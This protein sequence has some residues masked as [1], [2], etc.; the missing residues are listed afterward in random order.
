M[1]GVTIRQISI[2]IPAYDPDEQ[3][4]QLIDNLIDAGFTS[5]IVVD[6]GSA[7]RCAPIFDSIEK[8]APCT[9]LQHAVNLG[10]GRALKTGL[11]YLLAQIPDLRGVVTC[12]A[13]GQHLVEDIVRVARKLSCNP[14]SLVLG[15]RSFD[16]NVPLR[17]K[18]GNVITRTVFYLLAGRYLS[19]TQT[20][21]RG[22][23]A[24]FIPQLIRLEGEGYEYEMNMLIAT[25]TQHLEVIEESINTVYLD[26]NKSSHFNP[27]LDS[28]KIYFLLLRFSFSSLAASMLDVVLFSLCFKL[29]SNILLSLL[30]GRYTIG[31][32]VNF[33]INRNY[34]FHHTERLR[35][36]FI[37][38]YLFATIMGI[39]AYLMIRVVTN[40]FS[41][42]VILAKIAVETF[43]F[44]IS[45]TMQRDY[46]FAHHLLPD[47]V[48]GR[49]DKER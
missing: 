37:K 49:S 9:L 3:L 26:N 13:D 27:L 5:I 31:P 24:C 35:N 18:V 25:K 47:T 2:L 36:T 43:L 15:V 11:N 42:S 17:S 16:T 23:P 34:V 22:I 21:L 41:V 7:A 6:D 30:I 14:E 8:K 12:D 29:T 44:I 32:F 4:P 33:I 19:D 20:G 39:C 48:S 10:K 38:Y 45:F 46:I 1:Q 28:M 40:Q